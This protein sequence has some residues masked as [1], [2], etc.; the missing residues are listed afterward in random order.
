[1]IELHSISKSFN[2]RPVLQSLDL[3]IRQGET[4]VLIGPSGCGKSTLLRIMVGLIKPDTGKVSFDGAELTDDRL[5]ES[6]RRMGFVLQS[7]GLF[8]HLSGLD[9]VTLMVRTLEWSAERI[10][11]RVQEL[12][13]L[14]HL[15][16]EVL[17][18]FPHQLSGGQRQRIAIMRGLMLDPAVLFLDE[19]MGA[20][21]P[22]IRFDL[23]NDLREIF[24][25][26]K[27][28]VVHVTHD[29]A[30]AGYLGDDVILLGEGR[31]IQRGPFEELINSPTDDFAARFVNAQRPHL[32]MP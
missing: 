16:L 24:R 5:L 3:S 23:Q 31:I 10:R 26:L 20:L 1:M 25:S 21:D 30:E 32:G 4:T 2:G 12:A 7:G 28:T 17:Q 9:N 13:A 11:T 15:E 6:R 29:M 19:P 18:Q 22:L 8:P 14:T 27:K